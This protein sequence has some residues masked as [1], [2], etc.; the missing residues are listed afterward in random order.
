MPRALAYAL[1]ADFGDEQLLEL[2]AECT[3]PWIMS[4]VRVGDEPIANAKKYLVLERN[5]VRVGVM[6]LA[7]KEWLDTLPRP[8]PNIAFDDFID[9]AR[10]LNQHLRE[11]ENCRLVIALTHMRLPNDELLAQSVPELDAVFGGHDH[12][13]KVQTIN[14]VFVCKVRQLYFSRLACEMP[15]I[16]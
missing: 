4:N 15:P 16:C 13:Y 10:E 12:F 1:C 8:P 5:G 7:E 14:G 6:G 3:F 11:Q 2:V 9:V